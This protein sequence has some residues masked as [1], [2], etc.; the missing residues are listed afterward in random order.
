[1]NGK[2]YNLIID[3]IIKDVKLLDKINKKYDKCNHR[4]SYTEAFECEYCGCKMFRDEIE[5]VG[6]DN[7]E[8]WTPITE[9]QTYWGKS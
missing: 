5:I 6:E 8:Q 1:M 3:R 7:N 2:E 9:K 4:L